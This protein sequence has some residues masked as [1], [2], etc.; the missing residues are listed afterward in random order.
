MAHLSAEHLEVLGGEAGATQTSQVGRAK[1][2]PVS[3]RQEIEVEKAATKT[4]AIGSNHYPV[5]RVSGSRRR[6]W[7]AV[8]RARPAQ[9]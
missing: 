7:D 9:Q 6:L 5:I 2:P 3:S 4:A 1:S 8:Y